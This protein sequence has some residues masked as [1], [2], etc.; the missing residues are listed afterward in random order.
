MV[1]GPG[2]AIG[3]AAVVAAI[4]GGP[5]TLAAAGLAALGALGAYRTRGSGA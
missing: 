5:F 3:G 2:L 1:T 4:A